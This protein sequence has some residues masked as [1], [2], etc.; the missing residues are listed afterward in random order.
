MNGRI[1][2][3]T[4]YFEDGNVQ[5]KTDREFDFKIKDKAK[6]EDEITKHI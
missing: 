5:L 3:N 6:L 2:I 4:H 1:S